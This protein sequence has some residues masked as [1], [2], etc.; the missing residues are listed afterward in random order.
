MCAGAVVAARLGLLVYGADDPKT[1]AVRTVLNIPDSKASN[2]LVSVVA[3]VAADRC[4]Q[5]L[6]DWFARR[7]GHEDGGKSPAGAAR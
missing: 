5:Q 4:Q 6:K 3:G 2:H 7:R 1:G